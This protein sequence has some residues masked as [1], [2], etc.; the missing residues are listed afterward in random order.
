MA[1]GFAGATSETH[2]SGYAWLHRRASRF[3]AGWLLRLVWHAQWL[4]LALLVIGMVLVLGS[5]VARRAPPSAHGLS[6][7]ALARRDWAVAGRADHRAP[8]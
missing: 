7:P 2:D 6:P 3:V 5:I 1:R 4:G 8:S